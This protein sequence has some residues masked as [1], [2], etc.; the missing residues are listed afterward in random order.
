M[1]RVSG[2]GIPLPVKTR[3]QASTRRFLALPRI[4]LEFMKP[5]D[6]PHTLTTWMSKP[7]GTKIGHNT[8]YWGN[9]G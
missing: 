1:D 8:G 2:Y 4:A 7:L 5:C 3:F 6:L 9:R